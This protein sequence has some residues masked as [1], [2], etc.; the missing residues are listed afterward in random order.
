MDKQQHC[1][2]LARIYPFLPSALS[3]FSFVI[4]VMFWFIRVACLTLLCSIQISSLSKPS[5]W[6]E[7]TK[8]K[9]ELKVKVKLKF[10]QHLIWIRICIWIR[11]SKRL[12]LTSINLSATNIAQ[13]EASIEWI[14]SQLLVS[15]LQRLI[16]LLL[17]Q[18]FSVVGE[19]YGNRNARLFWP[20]EKSQLAVCMWVALDRLQMAYM[21][22]RGIEE[23]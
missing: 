1:D 21:M 8:V 20:S 4:V 12:S 3:S 22:A 19:C 6:V 14:L 23:G 5:L 17:K 9:L 16:W 10:E 2:N 7:T 15:E 18:V 11:P 13:V